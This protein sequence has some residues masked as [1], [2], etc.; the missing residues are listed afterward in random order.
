MRVGVDAC[1]WSSKRGFGRFTR[2]LLTALLS[3]D[4]DNEAATADVD[5]PQLFRVPQ[6][7]GGRRVSAERGAPAIRPFLGTMARGSARG[8]PL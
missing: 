5:S 8:A 3:V 6:P 1:C 7:D 2:E 4:H